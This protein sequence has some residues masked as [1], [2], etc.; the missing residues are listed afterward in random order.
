MYI[1]SFDVKYAAKSFERNG[2]TVILNIDIRVICRE[3]GKKKIFICVIRIGNVARDSV[4]GG[5]R[6]LLE[7]RLE[8]KIKGTRLA[9][10]SKFQAVLITKEKE[11]K[12]NLDQKYQKI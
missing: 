2:H 6:V 12:K 4:K 5:S 9:S 11:E 10:R 7:S 8:E 1:Y 3:R